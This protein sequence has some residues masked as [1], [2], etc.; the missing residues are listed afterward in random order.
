MDGLEEQR[1]LS[2]LEKAF[3]GLVKGLLAS[4]LESKRIYWK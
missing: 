4:L 2:N 3:K 1:P